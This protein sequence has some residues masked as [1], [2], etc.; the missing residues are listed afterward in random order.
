M[1]KKFTTTT[2]KR[3]Y[4]TFLQ[5]FLGMLGTEGILIIAGLDWTQDSRTIIT[6]IISTVIAPAIAAGIAAIMNL[7]KEVESDGSNEG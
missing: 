4:R 5:A 7:E 3:T 2:W 1:D 6:A